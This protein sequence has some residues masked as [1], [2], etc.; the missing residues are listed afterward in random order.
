M[1]VV[2]EV[3]FAR[4]LMEKQ[5]KLQ[6]ESRSARASA[7]S[8]FEQVAVSRLKHFHETECFLYRPSY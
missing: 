8:R 3:I 6:T 4:L 2:D 1:N 7:Q 5:P